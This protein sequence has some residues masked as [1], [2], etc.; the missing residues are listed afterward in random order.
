MST[1]TRYRIERDSLGE[2]KLPADALYGPH[3]QRAIENFP[4]SGIPMPPPFIHALGLIKASAARANGELGQLEPAVAEAIAAAAEEVARGMHDSQFPVDVF[5]TGS[6]T[7]SN[8]NANEVI[9]NLASKWLGQPVH[10]NDHVNK[11]QSSNDVIPTATH[12]SARLL[13]RDALFP[14][15]NALAETLQKRSMELSEVVKTGRTHLQ[16]AL[17]LTFGKELRSW[18]AL[19]EHDLER[20]H[21]TLPRLEHLAQGGT[22]IGSGLNAHPAF[23]DLFAVMLSRM[24]GIDF[25]PSDNLFSAIASQDTAVELSGQL[26][27]T[28][29]NLTKIANDLRWMSSGPLSGLGEITLPPLQPGSSI[30]PGKINPVIPEAVM[31]VGAQIAG[32]DATIAIAGQSGNFQL[33]TMLPVIAY[34]LLQSIMLLANAAHLLAEKVIKGFTVNTSHIKAT[35]DRNPILA[36]ALNDLIGYDK[37]VEIVNRAYRD[38]RPIKAVA[39][40]M[41]DLSKEDIDRL[42]DPMAL[43]RNK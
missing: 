35:L 3:T 9:A 16:D 6:G 10:P 21:N 1:D 25:R 41:T 18:A 31:M 27:V 24:T 7:S 8:M 37:V 22:A 2:I 26:R 15:L 42:L 30:M 38:G 17:P 32:N 39:A 40:E 14:S 23:A 12:L 13:L 34:N 5:Q 28:A 20:L 33:N 29:I 11:G 19:V 36:T 4:I 43:T